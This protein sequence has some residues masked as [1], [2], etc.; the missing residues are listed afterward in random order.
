MKR[1]AKRHSNTIRFKE[2]C[3][4]PD[5]IQSTVDKADLPDQLTTWLK[6]LGTL[7]GVPFNY[8]VPNEKMLPDESI[9]FFQVDFNWL[10]AL[11]EGACS[12]GHS[13]KNESASHAL[14]IHTLHAAAAIEN[15]QTDSQTI[16]HM[17]GF[18]LRSQVVPGWPKLEVVAF[19][20]AGNE[21]T[22]VVRMDRL[23]ASVLLYMV[24][25]EID[26]V[27]IREPAVGLHFGI[28]ISGDKY[29]RYV[30]VPSSAPKETQPG[31][32][33]TVKP[34]QPSFRNGGH[35]TLKVN[36]LALSMAKTLHDNSADNAPDG[37]PLPFTSAEFTLEMVEGTQE[38]RFQS[39]I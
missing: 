24:E 3:S 5:N 12:I 18:F 4:N 20:Q 22:N 19:D 23:S 13:S 36:Q 17:T 35:R 10:Y 11:V 8:L 1:F 16:E 6:R 14:L 31:D 9:R 28:E 21:L 15:L 25:G 33:M 27:L 32:Q 2:F 34:Q 7:H 37:S 30:T 26:H 38:V 39:K 29:L